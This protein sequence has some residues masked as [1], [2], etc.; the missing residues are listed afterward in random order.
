[1]DTWMTVLFQAIGG[2]G[3][4]LL[5]L[6]LLTQGLRMAGGTALQ[7][8]LAR[9]TH[10]P[11]RGL[12]LGFV[13]TVVLQAS[14]IVT[15]I[16]IG[17]V[18]AAVMPLRNAIW[19]IFGANIGTTVTG[20][21]VSATGFDIDLKAFALPFVG[22]GM[23]TRM[24]VSH[25]GW[26]AAGTAIAGIGL[27]FVGISFLKDAFSAYAVTQDFS[28]LRDTGILGLIGL[29]GAGIVMTVLIQSSTAAL[30]II[31]TGAA[32]GM[33]S[34]H[35]GAALIVGANLGTT[36]TAILA[37]IGAS[38]NARRTSAAHVIFNI[39][40]ALVVLPF[41]SLILAMIER[42]EIMAGITPNAA[43]SLAIFHTAF[44]VIGVILF[45]PFVPALTRFLESRFT[46]PSE[47]DGQTAFLDRSTI[48]LPSVAIDPL[49]REL[50]RLQR[51][52][53][54]HGL[55]VLD[56][57]ARNLNTQRA[58][59]QSL[60]G[61]ILSFSIALAQQNMDSATAET[62]QTAF[63]INRHLAQ[64]LELSPALR[65]LRRA[66]TH[67]RADAPAQEKVEKLLR[68]I[69]R[70]FKT[71]ARDAH[72]PEGAKRSLLRD[73]RGAKEALLHAGLRKEAPMADISAM[74]DVLSKSHRMAE[75]LVRADRHLAHLRPGGEGET[76]PAP[77][78]APEQNIAA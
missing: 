55:S 22:L 78:T 20:W 74:L 44:S 9:W 15:T 51:K 35:A 45:W 28:T 58:A 62:L 64:C 68:R 23:L 69:T 73:Y 6:D 10:T 33:L 19:T 43:V 71:V 56:E 13:A 29:V 41:M 31:L 7:G 18:N 52:T 49:C 61:G 76:A 40:T 1:M 11:L 24:L 38:P 34:L 54:A 3:V 59:L 30:V 37:T 2:I 60:S 70:I 27:F 66:M 77:E 5:A 14:A 47:K 32:S 8:L 25:A 67:V 4:F 53:A 75:Q 46:A 48:E 39:V 42:L 16:V 50:A 57:H 36:S 21:V 17:L 72:L 65:E 12:W 63:K 26:R